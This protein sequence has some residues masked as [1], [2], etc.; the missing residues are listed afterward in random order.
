[1]RALVLTGPGKAEVQEVEPPVA[2]PGQVV[3]GIERAGVCGTD[4]E[5]FT[6]EMSYLHTG[7]SWYPLRPGHEWCGTVTAVG[8]GV[9]AAWLGRRVTGDTMLGCGRCDRCRKGRHH[10]C[11]DLAEIG[12]SRG[13]AGALAE[14]LAVPASALHALPDT[15]DAASGALVEP[16]GNALRSVHAAGLEPGERLLVLGT[17]TIGLLVALFARARGAEVH[18]MGRDEDGLRLARRL[19][20][21]DAWTRP[22]LPA[23]PWDAVVDASNA[24]HLPALAL[25]LVEPA[26]RVV[27]IGLAGT[28][29][30][31]DARDLLLKDV[32]AVGILGGSAGLP[33]AIAA[34]ADGSVDARP[35]VAATVGLAETMDVLAGDRPAGAG[36]GPKIHIDPRR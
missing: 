26:G 32:T 7:R 9:D 3:V 4:V 36:P 29:S 17:G 2:G 24:P 8:D 30:T 27:Y 11:A 16:G 1:M 35:L 22:S 33:G 31:L 12:I 20:F 15:V 10:V 13:R 23:L 34:Y 14:Q 28:P 5:L 19:G 18:L 25:E 21:D 6:G